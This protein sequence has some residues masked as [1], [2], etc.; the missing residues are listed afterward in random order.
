MKRVIS[1]NKFR[2]IV[3]STKIFIRLIRY[4]EKFLP[5][6]EVSDYW[7]KN[8]N[9]D[10]ILISPM[11][12]RFSS[13][14]DI[15]KSA[16]KLKIPFCVLCLSW[17]NISTKGLFHIE[18]DRLLVWHHEQKKEAKNLHYVPKKKI[19]ITGS[20]FLD[21]WFLPNKFLKVS[22]KE[23]CERLGLDQNK[24]IILYLGSSKNIIKDEHLIINE[25]SA[26]FLKSE[27]KDLEN[28][29]IV[30]RCHPANNLDSKDLAKSNVI[31]YP[32]VAVLPE[33]D[34]HNELFKTMCEH[35]D[36]V[37]GINTTAMVDAIILDKPVFS[38]E[39][40]KY[41]FS[42]IR[43]EHYKRMKASG[44]IH[45]SKE[46]E[47]LVNLLSDFFKKPKS[48][49]LNRKK[50]VENYVRPKGMHNVAGH[51]VAE[52][53]LSLCPP[54]IRVPCSISS[55]DD[56]NI[57][58]KISSIISNITDDLNMKRNSTL[59]KAYQNFR[60]ELIGLMKSD[61][62]TTSQYWAEE[63]EGFSYMWDASPLIIAKIREHCYHIT[64]ERSYTYRNHHQ[65]K[66]SRHLRR[67][68]QLQQVDKWGLFVPESREMGGFGFVSPKGLINTDTLKFYEFTIGLAQS[69][70]LPVNIPGSENR[71]SVIE[72][73]SGWG[74]YAYTFKTLKPNTTYF[75]V[76]LPATLLFS[77]TY[78]QGVFPEANCVIVNE[79]N[80]KEISEN[81]MKFDFV[82][83]SPNF[84]QMMPSLKFNLALN[85]VSFQEMTTDQVE[86]YARYI[87]N[88]GCQNFYS[89][90][91]D[92]S[93]H[94]QELTIVSEIIGKYF[95]VT[96]HLVLDTEYCSVTQKNPP[97][98]TLNN[99][100]VH[101]YR[102]IFASKR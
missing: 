64:G 85:M 90:N 8:I 73:G 63:I 50:F 37:I 42:Q 58:T 83:I 69:D 16:F 82:F 23:F 40:E 11:N 101:Q 97:K 71:L 68:A 88:S 61:E 41:K 26:L 55:S 60:D 15:A 84:L 57:E 21:K 33:L 7:L 65:H 4:I 9:P 59:Y 52:E 14:T 24:K 30:V 34:E 72:I 99:L 20:P 91:R 93:P 44:A 74:G 28:S 12:M 89:L 62:T 13:E 43:T 48:N 38:P 79:S 27:N 39:I 87:S 10:V 76:D 102:H 29:Q 75:L 19:R 78:L 35:A 66:S 92:R 96:E 51:V 22:K 67:F 46:L 56:F 81:W 31:V 54:E 70:M 2:T 95:N 25:L 98:L 1:T 45:A 6:Y 18:P 5:S 77:S 86:T 49:S 100:G 36:A 32:E 94:N 80:L 17:D 47:G 3:A 53:V